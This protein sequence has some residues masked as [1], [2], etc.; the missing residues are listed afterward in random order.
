MVIIS[1]LVI[2]EAVHVEV[3]IFE[4]VLGTTVIEDLG[5]VRHTKQFNQVSR[6]NLQSCDGVILTGTLEHGAVRASPR[7]VLEL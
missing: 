3:V 2:V 7:I 1:L 4:G 6:C 5:W